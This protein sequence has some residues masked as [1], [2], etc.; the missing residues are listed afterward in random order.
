MSYVTASV[1]MHEDLIIGRLPVITPHACACGWFIHERSA[2][3]FAS[4][5][6]SEIKIMVSESGGS[7][8]TCQV[9]RIRIHVQFSNAPSM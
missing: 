8:S 5:R 3:M 9:L 6:V 4:V 1:D 7:T 2:A